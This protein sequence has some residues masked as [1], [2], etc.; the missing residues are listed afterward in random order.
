MTTNKKETHTTRSIDTK[1]HSENNINRILTISGN[2]IVNAGSISFNGW[3]VPDTFS[4]HKSE[5][6]QLKQ[7]IQDHE[8]RIRDLEAKL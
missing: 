5:I 2:Y 7:I 8:Q 1:E 3:D 6:A 4:N